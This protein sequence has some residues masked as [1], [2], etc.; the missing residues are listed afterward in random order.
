M[1]ILLRVTHIIPLDSVLVA[2]SVEDAMA[3]S[4]DKLQVLCDDDGQKH[5]QW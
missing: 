2:S 3:G 5:H 1:E 4:E